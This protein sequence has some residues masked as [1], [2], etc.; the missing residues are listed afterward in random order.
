MARNDRRGGEEPGGIGTMTR[1]RPGTGPRA[2][3]EQAPTVPPPGTEVAAPAPRSGQQ[4]RNRLGRDRQARQ[5]PPQWPAG[6]EQAVDGRP[7]RQG[8][9]QPADPYAA[10]PYGTGQYGA[11]PGAVTDGRGPR[12]RRTRRQDQPGADPRGASP[13]GVNARRADPPRTDPP[14]TDVRDADPRGA[15][16]RTRAPRN[17]AVFE[18]TGAP[19]R[20]MPRPPAQPGQ[21]AE[22]DRLSGPEQPGQRVQAPQATPES[23][24][25]KSVLGAHRMPFVLLLCGLLGGALV[26]ALVISTTLAAGSFQITR[27]QESTAALAKQRQA[28]EQQVA[29]AKSAEVIAERASKLGMHPAGLIQF[30]NLKTG[31]TLDDKA[32][33]WLAHAHYPGYTP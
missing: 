20:T 6:G 9:R 10:G 13:R 1:S 12:P 21:P 14:R 22:P 23:T 30:I 4:S 33:G 3:Q 28:L 19:P 32:S 7:A 29:Q 2:R 5:V 31:K 27:L 8:R 24:V 25:V 11:G 15:V 18:R 17:M 26:S 16:P